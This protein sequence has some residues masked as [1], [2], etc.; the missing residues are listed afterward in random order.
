M[1]KSFELSSKTYKNGRR[2]FKAIL[3]RLQPSDCVVNETGTK[4]N[5][6]GITFLREYC[7]PQLDSIKDMSVTVSFVDNERTVISGHGLTD[8]EDGFPTFD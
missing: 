4:Y 6:N 8:I 3:Y 7:E 5:L 1:A 2:K